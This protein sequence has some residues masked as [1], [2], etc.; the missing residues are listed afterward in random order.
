MSNIKE[1]S[2]EVYESYGWKV[3]TVD[4]AVID[5]IGFLN[6]DLFIKFKSKNGEDGEEYLFFEVPESE[7]EAFIE[8]ELVGAYFIAEIAN[9]YD[10]IKL[11]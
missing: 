7:F 3:V 8:A 9:D 10:F 6:N 2:R 4:S 5:A 11:K 1:A